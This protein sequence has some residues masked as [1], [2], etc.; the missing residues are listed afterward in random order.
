MLLPDG[1]S[2]SRTIARSSGSPPIRWKEIGGALRHDD[3]R[4]MTAVLQ[5]AKS[6][7]HEGEQKTGGSD[8]VAG[9]AVAAAIA[10][11]AGK[12]LP[13]RLSVVERLTQAGFGLVEHGTPF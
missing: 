2:R 5:N 3:A 7:Y 9:D 11:A 13:G 10:E 6:G 8:P 4:R 12:L 1:G